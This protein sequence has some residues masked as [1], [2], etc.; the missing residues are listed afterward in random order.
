MLTGA[1]ASAAAISGSSCD[2]TST[3]S[4]VTPVPPAH[5]E[6]G[7]RDLAEGA[8]AHRVHEHGEEVAAR[9]RG[10]AQPGE[11]G[12]ALARVVRVEVAQPCQLGLLLRLGGARQRDGT[13]ELVDVGV[14]IAEGVH[15]DD[16]E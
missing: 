6:E 7:L 16:G 5:V 11:G 4:D 8:A 1:A 15:P 14:G 10:L 9:E 13:L 12:G 2:A 3:G